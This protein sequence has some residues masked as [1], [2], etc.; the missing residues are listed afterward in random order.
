MI[1]NQTRTPQTRDF[2]RVLGQRAASKLPRHTPEFH[3]KATR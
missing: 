3:P 1:K 2:S